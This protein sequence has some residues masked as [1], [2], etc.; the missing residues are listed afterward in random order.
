MQHFTDLKT[1]IAFYIMPLITTHQPTV[2]I[3][4]RP[5]CVTTVAS[6]LGWSQ[7]FYYLFIHRNNRHVSSYWAFNL[8][9]MDHTNALGLLCIEKE[10]KNPNISE[11][12]DDTADQM[13]RVVTTCKRGTE[14]LWRAHFEY[15]GN[16]WPHCDSHPPQCLD[17]APCTPPPLHTHTHKYCV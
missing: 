1:I 9:L 8:L 15:Q 4:A 6:H 11:C 5:V 3:W 17:T 7:L 10:K 13:S 2:V 16:Q 14:A 12:R